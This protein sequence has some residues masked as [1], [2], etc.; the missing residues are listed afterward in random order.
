MANLFQN[1]YKPILLH[2]IHK[3]MDINTKQKIQIVIGLLIIV[4][5][6]AVCFMYINDKQRDEEIINNCGFTQDEWSCVC[7]QDAINSYKNNITLE[8]EED[9][10]LPISPLLTNLNTSVE[11]NPLL[12]NK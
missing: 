10:P 1:I 5:L 9:K 12:L 2:K 4:L 7:T 6:L 3:T 8:I 11:V